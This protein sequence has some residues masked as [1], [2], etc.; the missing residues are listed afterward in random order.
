MPL[1][2]PSALAG[3]DATELVFH[4]VGALRMR[5]AHSQAAPLDLLLVRAGWPVSTQMATSVLESDRVARAVVTHV[6]AAPFFESV[7]LAIHPKAELEAPLLLA[8]LRVTPLGRSNLFVDACGPGVAHP[9]FMSRFHDP[10]VRVLDGQPRGVRKAAVPDWIAPT[11][12]G[13]GA[14]LSCGPGSGNDL[15]RALLRYVSA[16]LDALGGAVRADQPE[17]NVE[18]VR[19]VASTVKKNGAA[20]KWLERSFGVARTAEYQRLLWNEA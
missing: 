14:R 11:S 20:G 17:D 8:D 16:Y 2:L 9:S 18:R 10:L 5:G 3:I 4:L 13:T 19:V 1:R 15:S 12:G 7:S 6:R